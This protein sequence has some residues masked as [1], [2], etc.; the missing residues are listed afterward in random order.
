MARKLGPIAP[1]EQVGHRH[2]S[3]LGARLCEPIGPDVC[4][5]PFVHGDD[6]HISGFFLAFDVPDNDGYRSE[7][8]VNVDPHFAGERPVW[9]MTGSL[10]GGDLTLTPSI[11]TR[12]VG[13]QEWHGYIT[14]GRWVPV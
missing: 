7:G 14:N 10:E 13:D 2:V 11:R 12:R 4:L 6:Q 8:A 1:V 3:G 9:T 5:R